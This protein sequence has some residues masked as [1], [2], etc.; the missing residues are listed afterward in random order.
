MLYESAQLAT[1]TTDR[2]QADSTVGMVIEPTT[3]T[4]AVKGNGVQEVYPPIT[5]E[6]LKQ[7]KPEDIAENNEATLQELLTVAKVFIYNL[8]RSGDYHKITDVPATKVQERRYDANLIGWS[9]AL[10]LKPID[11]ALNC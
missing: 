8:V 7:V 4:L 9:L 10:T 5:V 2:A 6:I 1:V 11:N 3:I